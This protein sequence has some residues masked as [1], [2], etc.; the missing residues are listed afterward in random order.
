MT[1]YYC[2]WSLLFMYGAMRR[3][4][5]CLLITYWQFQ[6]WCPLLSWKV[7]SCLWI[8]LNWIFLS[9]RHN[10]ACDEW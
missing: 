3:H 2:D 8:Q 6:T 7:G 1:V 4:F 5:H 10:C 9:A